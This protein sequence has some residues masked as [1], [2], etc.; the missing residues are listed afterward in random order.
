MSDVEA[1]ILGLELK[2][3]AEKAEDAE[4]QAQYQLG[5][6]KAGLEHAAIEAKK[7][8]EEHVQ[9][10]SKQS[11]IEKDIL[12]ASLGVVGDEIVAAIAPP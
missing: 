9:G 10:V 11:E 6:A 2:E 5:E 1:T 12:S 8:G 7:K 3:T 4:C